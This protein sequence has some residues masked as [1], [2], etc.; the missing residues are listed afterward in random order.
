MGMAH[1]AWGI[2]HWALGMGHWALERGERE[3][4]ANF[5][6]SPCLLCLPCS[7]CSL[8]APSMAATKPKTKNR[9]PPIRVS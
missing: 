1:G 6:F 8:Y 9:H 3:E 4:R 7:P 5:L 2:G